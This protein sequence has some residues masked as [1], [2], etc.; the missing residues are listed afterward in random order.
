MARVAVVG[1]YGTAIT[2]MAAHMPRAGETLLGSS[3]LAGP[4][5]KGSNQAVAARRLGA[6]V[7]LLTCVGKDRGGEEGRCLWDTEGIEATTVRVCSGPTM[8]GIIL[9]DAAGENRIVV[10]PGALEE[11]SEEDVLAFS[12]SIST[13]DIC[14]VSLEI[15]VAAALAALR[16][17]RRFGTRTI[18][19]P[20]PA[21]SLPDEAYR[22][23]DYLTPNLEEARSLLEAP[24]ADLAYLA[25]GFSLMHGYRGT[26]ILTLGA[27]G[28]LICYGSSTDHV[29]AWPAACVVDTTGAGDA[30]NAGLAVALADK[31]RTS[32]AV[33]FATQ[34]A[35]YCVER[36]QVIPALPR[37]E[38]LCSTSPSV[39]ADW[40]HER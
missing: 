5:G 15:P 11:L 22:L 7:S 37:R 36:A 24:D 18:L 8:A 10:V 3:F 33:S 34:V 13:A 14:L 32:E 30:F 6:S 26:V 31:L 40:P 28:V 23:A 25:K 21:Q 20:A 39:L 29:P 35:S 9:V 2:V 4:G 12:P 1:G 16:E 19:N 17:A 27:Q 38:E